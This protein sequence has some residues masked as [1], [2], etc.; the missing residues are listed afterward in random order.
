MPREKK[1][2]YGVKGGDKFVAQKKNLHKQGLELL[3]NRQRNFTKGLVTQRVHS[4]A[5]WIAMNNYGSAGNEVETAFTKVG[6]TAG[7]QLEKLIISLIHTGGYGATLFGHSS[8]SAD[9]DAGK[10]GDTDKKIR[11]CKEYLITWAESHDPSSSSV[12]THSGY[13]V[14]EE[15]KKEHVKKKIDKKAQVSKDKKSDYATETLLK[16]GISQEEID[17]FKKN[18]GYIPKLKEFHL[19]SQSEQYE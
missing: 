2:G 15:E 14:T 17:A 9:K 5:N 3:D 10:Q 1:S 7:P 19:F 16:S 18:H 4:N 8:S 6:Y 13:K 11:A 12:T